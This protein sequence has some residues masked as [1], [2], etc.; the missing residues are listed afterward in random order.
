MK[1]ALFPL[2]ALV[3]FSTACRNSSNLACISVG[4]KCFST[5][6]IKY[7]EMIRQAVNQ[8]NSILVLPPAGHQRNSRGSYCRLQRADDY[9]ALLK[10]RNITCNTIFNYGR[11]PQ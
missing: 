9:T 7:N 1:K 5:T 8:N 6:A 10:H 2:F 4:A 11:D 3:I